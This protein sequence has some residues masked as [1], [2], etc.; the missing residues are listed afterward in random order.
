MTLSEDQL[1]FY[2]QN[3]Y[4]LA[5]GLIPAPIAA[6]AEAAMWKLMG[7][8]AADASTWS[9]GPESADGY[10]EEKGE[11]I[12][13]GVQDPDLMACATDD[14]I[15]AVAQLLDEPPDSLHPPD[16]I[17]ALNLLARPGQWAMPGH[18]HVDG[19]NKQNAEL[20]KTFPGPYRT[21]CL[22]YLSDIESQGGGTWVWPGSHRT[23]RDLATSDPVKYEHLK[24]LNKEIPSLDLGT[25]VE[26]T[27]KRG[28]ILFFQPLFGHNGS[29]NAA[30]KPRFMIRFFCSCEQCYTTW[31]RG[32]RWSHWVA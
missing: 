3:G 20:A 22:L 10:N 12:F 24:D 27:P 13:H 2:R 23:L 28:D 19:L 18:P 1:T 5:S 16:S 11:V 7:M 15:T 31:P 17:F 29:I 26:L 21:T 25:G 14:F 6:Q 9:T 4:L 32:D 30:A 8:D